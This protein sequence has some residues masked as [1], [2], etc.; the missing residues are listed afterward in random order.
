MSLFF[1]AGLLE[2]KTACLRACL[3]CQQA[4]K[5][6]QVSGPGPSHRKQMREE[7]GPEEGLSKRVRGGWVWKPRDRDS[8]GGVELALLLEGI[9]STPP[10]QSWLMRQMWSTHTAVEL[11]LRLLCRGMNHMHNQLYWFGEAEWEAE[12]EGAR[13]GGVLEEARE[14]EETMV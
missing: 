4:W 8:E 9:R 6:C 3:G 1:F 7:E 13:E 14:E 2:Q 5:K 12:Q 11:E 10:E